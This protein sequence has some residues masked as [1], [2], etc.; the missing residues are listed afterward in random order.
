MDLTLYNT[1]I[2]RAGVWNSLASGGMKGL[3]ALGTGIKAT[4][5]AMGTVAGKGL[6]LGQAGASNAYSAGKLGLGFG[7]K[8]VNNVA[9]KPVKSLVNNMT[10]Q[11]AAY[12]RGQNFLSWGAPLQKLDY[13]KMVPMASRS[14]MLGK[15]WAGAQNLGTGVRNVG[16]A[17]PNAAVSV[18]QSTPGFGAF[19][20]YVLNNPV[21]RLAQFSMT[22][23]TQ[24]L[25]NKA[26]STPARLLFKPQTAD[27][28]G[29][30]ISSI[31]TWAYRA[32][33]VGLPA[34]VAYNVMKE[35][36]QAVV[37]SVGDNLNLPYATSAALRSE[38]GNS[39]DLHK[40]FGSDES[41]V[42]DLARNI[43]GNNIG[44][45]LKEQWSNVYEAPWEQQGTV[46]R[47]SSVLRRAT[48]AAVALNELRNRTAYAPEEITQMYQD[49]ALEAAQQPRGDS[50]ESYGQR[51]FNFALDDPEALNKSP[52]LAKLN[53]ARKNV[54][55]TDI[56][57]TSLALDNS[58]LDYYNPAYA[59][60]AK[61]RQQVVAA[62]E[63]VK[64]LNGVLPPVVA[65]P[66][67]QEL[68]RTRTDINRLHKD[69]FPGYYRE[70]FNPAEGDYWTLERLIPET[71]KYQGAYKGYRGL[72][73]GWPLWAQEQYE[74]NPEKSTAL[75]P[76][77]TGFVPFE[78]LSEHVNNNASNVDRPIH[79][80]GTNYDAAQATLDYARQEKKLSPAA[81][82]L[83]EHL[84]KGSENT[85]TMRK[86]IDLKLN[87]PE[88]PAAIVNPRALVPPPS[89]PVK[90]PQ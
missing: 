8:A 20:K 42:G 66:A 47:I 39:W 63:G 58:K 87:A 37:D 24:P 76:N 38:L 1:L 26:I 34:G 72:A 3:S 33:A 10:G 80:K 85:Q 52:I 50:G 65:D 69:V 25:L 22:P 64:S 49:R 15:T 21:R 78:N 40:D 60:L 46:G 30:R 57:N 73:E 16:R 53:D 19:N 79:I 13:G 75:T 17:I 54:G 62:Q 12:A 89:K 4:G 74:N 11:D 77:P 45:S 23:W 55:V 35:A 67:A 88:L 36:P 59:E 28:L 51:A 6:E 29:R 86:P 9:V 5:N 81:M 44:T 82:Q 2:K 41:P 18:A 90:P 32:G 84:I 14:T 56:S 27:M 48:P 61:R 31:P 7:A 71:S 83:L 68:D 70:I 43:A